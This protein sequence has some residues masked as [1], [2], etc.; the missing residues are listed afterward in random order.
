MTRARLKYNKPENEAE[1][2][3]ISSKNK[4][5]NKKIKIEEGD[6][7]ETSPYVGLENKNEINMAQ[8]PEFPSEI[9]VI[10]Q[11]FFSGIAKLGALNQSTEAIEKE[12]KWSYKKNGSC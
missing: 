11:S 9:A 8:E 1:I 6:L 3:E 12:K 7:S 10:L 2:A 4:I 5:E